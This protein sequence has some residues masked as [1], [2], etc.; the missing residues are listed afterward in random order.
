[1][2][3]QVGSFTQ[4]SME[5]D[6]GSHHNQVWIIPCRTRGHLAGRRTFR[7]PESPPPS[8]SIFVF[9]QVIHLLPVPILLQ[10]HSR[11]AMAAT[12]PI[13]QT[14]ATNNEIHAKLITELQ[15]QTMHVPDM[16]SRFSHW[17]ARGRN[18]FYNR[19]KAEIDDIVQRCYPDDFSRKKA[20]KNNFAF[21]TSIWYPDI[22]FE[23]LY[24]G[25]IFSYWIFAVDDLMDANGEALSLDI[26]ASTRYREQ[27]INFC[28]YWLGLESL[29]TRAPAASPPAKS[30]ISSIISSLF[31]RLPPF[32]PAPTPEPEAPNLPTGVFKE[33]GQ[34]VCRNHSVAFREAFAKEIALYFDHCEIEQ[35]E[36]LTGKTSPDLETYL[37][38]RYYTSAVRLYCYITQICYGVEIP[39]WIVDTPEMKTVWDETDYIILLSNDILSAK[40]ELAAGCV[41]NAV[42]VMYHQGQPLSAIVPQIVK[43]MEESRDRFDDAAAK[44]QEM[45]KKQPDVLAAV[46][47]Y[48][49]GLKTISTGTIEFCTISPRYGLEPY[50]NADGSMDVV[51]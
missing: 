41:H 33:F 44:I 42:P 43:R 6:L 14:S 19:L 35:R 23:H 9:P 51:L 5:E 7:R 46:N 36:R 45:C 10:S 30:T 4:K 26:D 8:S 16:L 15:G 28:R 3:S 31:A 24:T 18:K 48:M 2:Q 50:F 27:A 49:D 37:S 17:P 40:K 11:S 25:G 47:Q 34:R 20:N 22:D 12:Q 1:M 29:P 32:H 21:F 13:L 39:Q 38:I